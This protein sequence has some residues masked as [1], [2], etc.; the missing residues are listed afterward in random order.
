MS[1]HD[2][3]GSKTPDYETGV[4]RGESGRWV[5]PPKS[6]GRPVGP[7]R[8]EKIATF[9]EPHLEGTLTK[10]AELAKLGDGKSAEL[11]LK[12]V[13]PPARPDAERVQIPGFSE[14]PD[15][16]SKAEAVLAAAATGHCSAEAAQKLL[17]VLDVYARAVHATEMEERL[18]ALEAGRGTPKPVTTIDGNTGKVLPDNYEDLA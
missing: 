16:K 6:P 3:D 14:A 10:L 2:H 15:L 18:S 9:L 8:A 11:L 13:A 4:V 1:E 17:A 5:K 12:Y 7:S